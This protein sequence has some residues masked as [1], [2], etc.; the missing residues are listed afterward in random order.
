MN[1]ENSHSKGWLF[2]WKNYGFF[3]LNLAVLCCGN[4]NVDAEKVRRY[5]NLNQI[6]FEKE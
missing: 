5:N 3:A 1:F 2:F 6:T 4:T